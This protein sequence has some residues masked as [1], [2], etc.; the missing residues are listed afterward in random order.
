MCVCKLC[1]L[2]VMSHKRAVSQA[3]SEC[4]PRRDSAGLSRGISVVAPIP[5]RRSHVH[6]GHDNQVSAP[7]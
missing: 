5:R 3:L 7:G 2:L 1:V 6:T 4:C